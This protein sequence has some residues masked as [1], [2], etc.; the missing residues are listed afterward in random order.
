MA[1]VFAL[2]EASFLQTAVKSTQS[3]RDCVARLAV[4][5]PDHRHRRLL[6]P[7]RERPR[8]RAAEQRDELAPFQLR[9][10]HAL[11]LARVAA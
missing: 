10:L 3:I 7:R 4:E 1:F 5:E 11:P 8:H 9:E 2:G 6:R